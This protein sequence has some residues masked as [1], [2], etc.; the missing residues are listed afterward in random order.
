M[1]LVGRLGRLQFADFLRID[2]LAP[3]AAGTDFFQCFTVC[4]NPGLG[5]R[6]AG[7]QAFEEIG[8]FVFIQPHE[9]F[10]QADSRRRVVA[11]LFHV[12][13]AVVVGFRFR[14]ATVFG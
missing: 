6:M 5:R 2:F 8:L 12:K 13:H 7:K 11:C 10:L 14:I 3:F 4:I 1:R 9:G